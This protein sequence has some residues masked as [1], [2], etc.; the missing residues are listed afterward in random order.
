MMLVYVD[1]ILITGFD[2]ELI[3]QLKEVLCANFKSIMT[4][5]FLGIE[6][7]RSSDGIVMNQRKYAL[8]LISDYGLSAAK[9]V[10]TPLEDN[11][12]ITSAQYDS[13]FGLNKEDESLK[14]QDN[15]RWLI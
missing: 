3:T 10:I 2:N 6:I 5:V 12:K 15:Y 8:E 4:A 11:V 13:M 9:P 14:D 7:A 1:D